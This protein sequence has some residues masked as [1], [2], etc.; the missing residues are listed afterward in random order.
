[1]DDRNDLTGLL[2]WTETRAGWI[3]VLELSEFLAQ[4]R[5]RS[6]HFGFITAVSLFFFFSS[7]SFFT[8]FLLSSFSFFFLLFFLP[9]FPFFL[10]LFQ[11]PV[12]LSFFHFL[13]FRKDFWSFILFVFATRNS[14]KGQAK[15]GETIIW[16]VLGR[17]VL[18][19]LGF[20]G[21]KSK[22]LNRVGKSSGISVTLGSVI[23]KF[24]CIAKY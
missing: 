3:I 9:L 22:M 4:S 12:F 5:F 13:F 1:M 7:F 11:F 10:F 18:C 15:A 6:I 8:L 14:P 16:T 20:G 17:F 23:A 19:L 24:Y 2:R 21:S